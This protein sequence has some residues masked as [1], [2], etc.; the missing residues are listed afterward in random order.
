[1]L[2]VP[3]GRS[4]RMGGSVP[5][6]NSSIGSASWDIFQAP[7]SGKNSSSPP[8]QTS[9]PSSAAHPFLF[10]SP[11]FPDCHCYC[12]CCLWMPQGWR[13]S[14]RSTSAPLHLVYAGVAQHLGQQWA[15]SFSLPGPH[16]PGSRLREQKP[17]QCCTHCCCFQLSPAHCAMLLEQCRS[18]SGAPPAPRA[19]RNS[20][21]GGQGKWGMR[22]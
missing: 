12:L 22:G 3:R 19:A 20:G 4:K 16:Q 5:L 9:S 11:P 15:V 14:S 17:T 1:M 7:K 13:R 6:P 10:H 8:P 2:H 21:C 18:G